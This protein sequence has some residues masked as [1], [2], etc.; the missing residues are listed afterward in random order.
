[1]SMVVKVAL[2]VVPHWPSQPW[3]SLL[4]L[5]TVRSLVLGDSA[6]VLTK[7][8][9]MDEESKLPPGTFLMVLVRFP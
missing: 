1:M 6:A 2:L 3:W 7:G 8:P 4:K 5:Y 9:S